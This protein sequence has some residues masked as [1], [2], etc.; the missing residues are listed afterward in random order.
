[1]TAILLGCWLSMGAEKCTKKPEPQPEPRQLRR[2]VQLAPIQAPVIELPEQLGR[3]KFDFAFVANMQM[4]DILS[5]TQSFTTATIDPNETWD[6]SDLNEDSKD[7]FNQCGDADDV[8]VQNYHYWSNSKMQAISRNA[9]CMIYMPQAK[10]EG[11]VIDFTLTTDIDVSLGL[12]EIPFLNF[13]KFKMS[14]YMISV[15]LRAKHPM[16]IGD[17]YFSTVIMDKW[18]KDWGASV[19]LDLGALTLGPSGYF[20]TPLKN[21][22]NEAFTEA[23]KKLRDQWTADEPWYAMVM[24]SCDKYIYI[25]GGYGNDVGLKTGDIVR[26]QNV[27]YFWDDQV[28]K[29]RLI[30]EIRGETVA[31]A[32][33]TTVGRN[34]SEAWIIQGDPNYPMNEKYVIYPGSRVYMEKMVEEKPA[35]PNPK[36]PKQVAKK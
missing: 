30:G 3:K 14:K 12:K 25:N 16:E 29:S 27:K 5:K 23:V 13:V 28:C 21:M 11:S 15:D 35:D 18:A 36:A 26:I 8:G 2:R 1:M 7:R 4:Y 32:K 20:K 9:A 33:V 34:I 19:G 31:Y 6:P 17:H 22:V 10:I 24:K